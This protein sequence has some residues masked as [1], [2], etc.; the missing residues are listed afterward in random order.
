MPCGAGE[1]IDGV[2][3]P[4]DAQP[5]QPIEDGID[6]SLRGTLA[7]GILDPQQHLAAPAACVEP[8]EQG[9]ARAADMEESGRRG[10]E[11]GDDRCGHF[12]R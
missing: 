12:G 4:G 11:A 9:C 3:V 1:L 8:V 2:T 5:F 7:V 10:G 6:R